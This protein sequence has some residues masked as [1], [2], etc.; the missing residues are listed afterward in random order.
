MSY[1]D[2]F[3]RKI[4]A[5][6]GDDEV[7]AVWTESNNCECSIDGD[8]SVDAPLFIRYCVPHSAGYGLFAQWEDERAKQKEVKR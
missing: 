5:A 7:I 4:K 1:G 3:A 2:K 6:E 8:G